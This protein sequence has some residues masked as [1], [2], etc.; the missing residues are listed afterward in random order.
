MRLVSLTSAVES[1]FHLFLVSEEGERGN[2]SFR[3]RSL[4]RMTTRKLVANTR[5][6]KAIHAVVFVLEE[7]PGEF[8]KNSGV[9][10]Y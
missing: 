7:A 4:I 10:T 5:S 8:M 1:D 2:R 6:K 3:T 9:V